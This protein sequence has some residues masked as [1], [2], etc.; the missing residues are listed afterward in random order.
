MSTRLWFVAALI[1][2]AGVALVGCENES[3]TPRSGSSEPARAALAT[4]TETPFGLW[5]GTTVQ[6]GLLPSTDH[7]P[8]PAFAVLFADRTLIDGAPAAG[9]ADFDYAAW[10]R[11][12]EHDVSLGGVAGTYTSLET[13]GKV[14][15]STGLEEPLVLADGTLTLGNATLRRAPN[16]TGTRLDGSYAFAGGTALLVFRP[17][18]TFD[19]GG[20]FASTPLDPNVAGKGTYAIRDYSLILSYADGRVLTRR[21]TPVP[22][23]RSLETQFLLV[24]QL[25]ERHAVRGS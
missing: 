20:V 2:S 13:A 12:V 18:G 23:G 3:A 16:V 4:E 24:D 10:A 5:I 7:A 25:V 14:T 21:I 1:A 9:L 17:D 11:G 22:D 19:D 8:A 15:L 6:P